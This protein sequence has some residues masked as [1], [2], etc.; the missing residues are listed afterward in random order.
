MAEPILRYPGAK[1][2]MADWI[3]SHLPPHDVYLEPYFGSGAVFFNKQPSRLET[4]ND[5][6]GDVVNLFHVLRNSPDELERMI[7]LTPWSREEY[8]ACT[9]RNG[10]IVKVDN[11]I[12]MARRFLVRCWQSM[13]GKLDARTGWRHDIKCDCGQNH[14]KTWLRLPQ[15]IRMFASRLKDAQIENRDAS[16]LMLRYK[17]PNV[18]IYVDPPY[19]LSTRAGKIYQDEMTDQQHINLLEILINHPGPVLLSGYDSEMYSEYLKSWETKYKSSSTDSGKKR[20]EV[21]WLNPKAA[22]Y[23]RGLF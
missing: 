18:C 20:Q 14:V 16:E 23:S 1:W 21:L 6:S 15:R 7:G 19:V 17:L 8:Y 13:S 3:I 2:N 9:N 12:E 22:M 10:S 5:I 11:E 4:I